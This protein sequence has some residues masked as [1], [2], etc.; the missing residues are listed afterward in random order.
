MIL[1]DS[2]LGVDGFELVEGI[3]DGAILA[4]FTDA[5]QANNFIE[6]LNKGFRSN[7]WSSINNQLNEF[8]ARKMDTTQHR[9][10]WIVV[11]CSWRT[12]F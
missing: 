10:L 7:R 2:E 5:D 3:T 8:V 12:S 6:K 4:G 9:E 11:D 1:T